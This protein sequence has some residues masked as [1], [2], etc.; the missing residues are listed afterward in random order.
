MSLLKRL[1]QRVLR[2]TYFVGKDLEGNKYFEFPST[3]NDLGRTKRT[4]KYRQNEDMWAYVASGK[5]LPVQ[6]SAW[7]THTRPN[8][9]TIHE[10]QADIVRQQRVQM[11]AAILE[12]RYQEERAR[13]AGINAVPSLPHPL[14]E[15]AKSA[16]YPATTV[17]NAA[18]SPAAGSKS[19]SKAPD[20]WTQSR[21]SSDQPEAWTPRSRPR[22]TQ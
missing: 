18:P 17:Q 4:V 2:P 3:S 16:S 7:L 21:T 8:P 6:W 11:N 9:P 1:W 13:V 15:S 10:L 22:D 19:T 14:E 5:R 12:A 20:P